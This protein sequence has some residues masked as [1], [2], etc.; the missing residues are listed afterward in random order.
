MPKIDGYD[1]DSDQMTKIRDHAGK[2]LNYL[3]HT[4]LEIME[5]QQVMGLSPRMEQEQEMLGLIINM[6]SHVIDALRCVDKLSDG[7]DELFEENDIR[8]GAHFH[9]H[10]DDCDVDTTDDANNE[11]YMIQDELWAAARTESK[12]RKPTLPVTATLCIGCLEERLGRQ[13]TSKDFRYTMGKRSDRLQDRTKD[14]PPEE[15]ME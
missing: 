5:V 7:I 12:S 8:Y 13:L 1:L 9:A 14:L 2:I 6:Y 15:I 10:C 3:I 11:Y 4:R